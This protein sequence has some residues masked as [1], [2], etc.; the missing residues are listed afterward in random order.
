MIERLTENTPHPREGSAC[1]G[2][3]AGA[4]ALGLFDII[5]SSV[6]VQV[7]NNDEILTLRIN[8]EWFLTTKTQWCC[9]VDRYGRAGT[10]QAWS[11]DRYRFVGARV[12]GMCYAYGMQVWKIDPAG[13]ETMVRYN[14]V[15]IDMEMQAITKKSLNSDSQQEM[16]TTDKVKHAISLIKSVS[17]MRN[18]TLAYSGGKDS[19][20]LKW[21]VK[22][23]GVKAPFVYNSTTID[24]PGT[25]SFCRS[26]G[27]VISRPRYSFLQLV[28]KKGYPTMFRRFC[29]EELK[30]KYIAD[31]LMTGVRKS[32]SVKRN[33]NYCAFEDTY[34]YTRKLQSQRLHPLLWFT[35][36][37]IDWLV[38]EKQIECHPLYYDE[39]GM[40]HVERRLGCIG[41]PL[42]GDRGVQDYKANPKFLLALVKAGNKFHTRLGRTKNDSY[43]NLVYNLFYSNGG[44]EKYRANFF[45]LF[46]DDPKQILEEQ[47]NIEIP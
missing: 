22:E 39:D 35:N 11:A 17:A 26:Q 34:V 10:S 44:Y 38:N 40:F 33:K 5:T 42:Q 32:E 20:V 27:A 4:Q 41:C 13:S 8:I 6:I 18:Y 3:H 45:G 24:P 9:T 12:N 29:C 30:E 47:F 14:V 1:A 28:E 23:A 36:D 31:Y 46:P 21:L 43:L 25:I 15:D 37:D 7:Y 16:C 2:A 19:Q